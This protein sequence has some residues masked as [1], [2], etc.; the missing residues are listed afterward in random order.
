MS[1]T[2]AAHWPVEEA[3]LVAQMAAGDVEAPVVR[4]YCRYGKRLYRFGV[5]QLG[6]EG[7]AVEMV[8]ETFVRL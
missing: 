6:N 5:Q 2:D 3:T 8:Q 1:V 7:L 4:L